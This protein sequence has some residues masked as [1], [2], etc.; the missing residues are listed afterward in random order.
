MWQRLNGE[1]ARAVAIALLD[2]PDASLLSG[3]DVFQRTVGWG[4]HGD[5][6]LAAAAFA[7]QYAAP[8]PDAELFAVEL[9][10]GD[11]LLDAVWTYDDDFVVDFIWTS[12]TSGGAE[13]IRLSNVQ[14]AAVE[15]F[16]HHL[17]GIRVVPTHSP[18][19]ATL[20][21]TG[22]RADEPPARCVWPSIALTGKETSRD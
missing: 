18:G 11:V 2:R 22:T 13:H 19:D 10:V 12:P 17:A 21:V 20:L 9:A 1:D 8:T 16:G 15:R 5:A 4:R 6:E 14:A 7:V 3:W